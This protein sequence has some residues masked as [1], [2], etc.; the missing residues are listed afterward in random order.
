MDVAFDIASLFVA[1]FSAHTTILTGHITLMFVMSNTI[2]KA[3]SPTCHVYESTRQ[4]VSPSF[5]DTR[6]ATRVRFWSRYLRLSVCS[7]RVTTETELL[8]QDRDV[9][10]S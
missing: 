1:L 5:E 8:I 3:N 9:S 6:L 4:G 10:S 7:G 2:G